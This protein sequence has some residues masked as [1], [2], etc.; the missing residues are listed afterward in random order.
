MKTRQTWSEYWW[1]WIITPRPEIDPIEL[2]KSNE[3]IQ[4]K[5][6][7]RSPEVG[8]PHLMKATTK[9]K[10]DHVITELKFVLQKRNATL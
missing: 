6:M 7:R 2:K 5:I 3:I 10:Y 1:S 8:L 9:T 4:N